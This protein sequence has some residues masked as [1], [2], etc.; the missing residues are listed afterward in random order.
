MAKG[1]PIVYLSAPPRGGVRVREAFVGALLSYGAYSPPF[2]RIYLPSRLLLTS[3]ARLRAPPHYS[4]TPDNQTSLIQ[5]P[6]S[7]SLRMHP[8]VA[9]QRC[10]M[11]QH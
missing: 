5:S 3:T 10:L 7:P 2:T 8:V 6:R 11:Q 9:L 1:A 4:H